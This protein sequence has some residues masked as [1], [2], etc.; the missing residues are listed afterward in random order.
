MTRNAALSGLA[1]CAL[2]ASGDARTRDPGRDPAMAGAPDRQVVLG[3]PSI[4]T[5]PTANCPAP[6]RKPVLST[7]FIH[8]AT[9][10]GG[11]QAEWLS[12]LGLLVRTGDPDGQKVTQYLGVMQVPGAGTAWA[13]NT[14][15][16][17]NASPG[18]ENS[19]GGFEGS[20]TPG[21]PGAI[22]ARNGSIGYELDFTNWD[23]ESAPGVGPFTV[24]Q[25]IHAQGSY[26]SLSGIYFD[27]QMAEGAKG[28]HAA[29]M[30]NGEAVAKEHGLFD[31]SHARNSVTIAGRHETG[32]N[33][34]QGN[35][36]MRAVVLRDGQRA[37]FNGLENC[38][39]WDD[40]RLAYTNRAGR[41]VFSIDED[42]NA[43]F[44][45]SVTT[46]ARP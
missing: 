7:Q 42:G 38:V 1:L 4:A 3:D 11:D 45:G 13:L 32:V 44:A 40:G 5:C 39:V 15:L 37:C 46:Q 12:N 18:G 27:A 9:R 28:W 19:F 31:G 6:P 33:T 25:Y 23:T 34:S 29:I 16:V 43:R 21:K 17:R 14:D 2:V 10:Q 26:T 20:G 35:R 30:L 8:G 24:G 22:G 41:T 36:D